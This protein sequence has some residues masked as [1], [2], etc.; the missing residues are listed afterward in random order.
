VAGRYAFI[1]ALYQQVLYGRMSPGA[2]AAMHL[3][4]ARRLERAYGERAGEIAGELAA[5]FA[6]GRDFERATR[7]RRLAGEHALRH[8]AYREA[9]EHA[10]R[11]L[12]LLETQ[13]ESRE[14][15]E[16]ELT[17]QMTLG[18]ALTAT[19]GY[20][21]D[22]V[23]RAYGRARDLCAQV[24]DTT[25]LLHVLRGVGRF[26][27]IRGELATAREVA[28][29]LL[30]LSEGRGDDAALLMAH[31]ALGV[32]SLYGGE[33]EA[34]LRHLE[35]GIGLYA[36][37]L[38]RPG[39][40]AMLRLASPDVTCGMQAAWALYLLGY[41]DRATARAVE[42][43]ALARSHGHPFTVAYACHLAAGIYQWRR[44]LKAVQA[45]EEEALAYDT[46]HGFGLLLTVGTIQRGWLRALGGQPEEGLTQMRAGLA[47]HR[48]IG[49]VL[50]VPGY[51]ALM[52]DLHGK[53]GRP[54]E[55]LAAATEA[56]AVARR[57]GGHYWESEVHRLIGVLTPRPEDAESSLLRALEVARRQRGRWLELRAALALA[58][59]WSGQGH[60]RRAMKLLSSVYGWFT[61]GFA[62]PDLLEAKA[63]LDE[64][65]RD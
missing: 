25:E 49:A 6:H 14:R 30:A 63:L 9:A 38:A 41:A 55:G 31:N 50:L 24:G 44:E 46:E 20:G 56:L 54:A 11:G 10:G 2:R 18:A 12:E 64:L 65:G 58:R 13:P 36:T 27:V 47:K 48:E 53:L 42:A 43:L 35:R 26:Y 22:V 33:F 4:T 19:E 23:A 1:H 16:R 57:S 39:R 28:T 17:L 40:S 8:H 15:N 29:H 7:Y 51:L 52:A 59:L 62:T 5:H 3:S 37:S 61:E 34:A 32:A 45:L 60:R 21:V